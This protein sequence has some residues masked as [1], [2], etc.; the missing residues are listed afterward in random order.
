MKG[1]PKNPA[2]SLLGLVRAMRDCCQ[3]QEGE[4]CRKLALTVSQFGCLLAMPEPA[5]ELNVHQ[6]A[7]VMGLS[8][9]RASRIVDSL[10]RSG[11][12]DRR[13]MDSDRRT[14]LLTL[15]PAGQEK[16]H[17]AHKLLTE[18]EKRLLAHLPP[19]RSQEMQETLQTLINAW[20]TGLRPSQW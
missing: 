14:Q 9:S 2:S 11:W 3:R 10:V 8:A 19:Q 12:L 17:L 18:C 13:T 4:M 20:G 1:G 15:T 6:V 5:G 16:W 7:K